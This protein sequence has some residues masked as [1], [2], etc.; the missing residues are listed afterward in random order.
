MVQKKNNNKKSEKTKKYLI[1]QKY[2]KI[3]L[4]WI[5]F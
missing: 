5:K 1:F 3:K 4:K 2:I